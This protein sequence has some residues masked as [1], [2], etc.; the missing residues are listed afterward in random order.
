MKD[1]IKAGVILIQ[2][3]TAV[4]NSLL[5]ETDP[6]SVGWGAL[7]NLGRR[8]LDDELFRAGWISLFH[9]REIKTKA[10][11]LDK[12]KAIRTAVKR[13]LSSAES[14]RFNSLEVRHVVTRSFLGVHSVMVF[15]R[16][17]HIQINPVLSVP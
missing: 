2:E 6:Y 8:E 7:K 10:V 14:R 12:R 16:P 3:G 5:L 11:G 9:A 15:A 13:L 1:Q 17:R 4:P